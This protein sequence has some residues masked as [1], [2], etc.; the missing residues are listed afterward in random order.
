[1][2]AA[3]QPDLYVVPKCLSP[4][5]QSSRSPCQYFLQSCHKGQGLKQH[6]NEVIPYP[7]KDLFQNGNKSCRGMGTAHSCQS[8]SAGRG[9][10][11]L[12][13]EF[14]DHSSTGGIHTVGIL[15]ARI[16]TSNSK[17]MGE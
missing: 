5:P 6:R 7:V 10:T 9:F 17:E 15:K 2:Y 1:M 16:R 4:T 13:G 3:R 11:F 12:L 8:S 14:G